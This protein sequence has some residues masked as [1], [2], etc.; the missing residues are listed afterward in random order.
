M[1][2][3]LKYTIAG[4]LSLNEAEQFIRKL[5]RPIADIYILTLIQR[6]IQLVTKHKQQLSFQLKLFV[7]P[8]LIC[9]NNE[10]AYVH[11]DICK[12]CGCSWKYHMN[13]TYMILLEE[14]KMIQTLE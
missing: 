4:T 2:M 9:V 3:N 13:V 8:K 7:Y 6:D 12:N 5:A 11:S 1:M 10:Y 14:E